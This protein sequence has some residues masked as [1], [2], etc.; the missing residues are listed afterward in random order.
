MISLKKLFELNKKKA[1]GILVISKDTKKFLIGLRSPKLDH[2]N[3]WGIPGGKMEPNEKNPIITAKREFKEETGF[4]G[5]IN[6][7]PAYIHNGS[8]FIYYN[9]IGIVPK[10][11]NAKGDWETVKFKWV[12]IDELTNDPNLHP[13]LDLLLDDDYSMGIINNFL[14][15]S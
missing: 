11:F 7:T 12:T 15:K 6:A 14:S 3:M 10:E 2:G 5:N 8:D 9:Y 13:G 1:A 4:Y